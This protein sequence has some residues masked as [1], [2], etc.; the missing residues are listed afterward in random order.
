MPSPKERD[1]MRK[2]PAEREVSCGYTFG[3][4]RGSVLH[5][6]DLRSRSDLAR[7]ELLSDADTG[8]SRETRGRHRFTHRVTILWKVDIW[9]YQG[10][11]T[12][13]GHQAQYKG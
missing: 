10:G 1:A 8:Q 2:H 12:A 11:I 4:T 13:Y 6:E 5:M 7:E 9:D 3:L